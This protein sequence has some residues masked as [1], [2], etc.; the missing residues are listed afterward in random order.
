MMLGTDMMD[1]AMAL[2]LVRASLD[3]TFCIV[4]RIRDLDD[5]P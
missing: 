1:R 2:A 4:V 3:D 5:R